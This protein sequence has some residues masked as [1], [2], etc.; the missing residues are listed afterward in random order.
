[1]LI[2]II[3]DT[4]DHVEN[5]KRAMEI[6][7]RRKVELVIH[8]GDWVSPFM[9][10]FVQGFRCVSV[11]GNNDGDIFRF[12]TFNQADKWGIEFHAESAELELDKRK[13]AVY[14]GGS[15]TLLNCL[16]E[17]K[18]FDVVFF[19]HN[20]TAAVVPGKPLLVNPGPACGFRAGIGAVKA[21]VAI[22][23]TADNTAKLVELK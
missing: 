5:T 8:C 2:G 13:I 22:Y 16:L 14:H 7:K 9:P 21:T 12:L 18:K 17:S 20:H 10:P 1:M 15:P 19:G 3:S 4:H 23:N 11:F 6:F